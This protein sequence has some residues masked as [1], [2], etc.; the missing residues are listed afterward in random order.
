MSRMILFSSLPKVGGHSTLTYGLCRMLRPHFDE[1]EIWCKTMPEHGHSPAVAKQI[2]A[3]GCK[4]VLLTDEKG[5]LHLGV[6]LKAIVSA[7]RN[8]PDVFFALAMR[9]LSLVLAPLVAARNS[10]YYHITHDLNPGTIKRLNLYGK[11]FKQMVFICPATYDEFPGAQTNPQF[12]WV[13][14]SSEIPVRQPEKL[15]S[16][17]NERLATIDQPIRY[18]LLGR[19]TAEKGSA[20]M[21]GYSDDPT[22][23]RCEL[24]VAGSGPYAEAFKER[25]KMSGKVKVRFHGAYDPS[26]RE[27]FLRTFFAG[28]DYLLVPSQDEWETLSMATLECLQHG[29]PA[30]LCRTGGLKSFGQAELGPA[31]DE[32]VRLIDP[33]DLQAVLNAL[34]VRPRRPQAVG[35]CR[36]YYEKFF[37]DK[38]VMQRWLEVLRKHS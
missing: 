6:L 17:R 5:T 12:T 36:D 14:Q 25:E 16:E 15:S 29:V 20:A 18:G 13:P 38:V 37:S 28:I 1:I 26:V 23:A 7:W 21:I 9:H 4:V 31:P 11:V 8:R 34:A 30:V 2:E 27:A 24:H 10:I 3:L 32:V 33:K 35:E 19:L 22:A